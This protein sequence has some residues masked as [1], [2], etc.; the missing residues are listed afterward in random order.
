MRGLHNTLVPLSKAIDRV[1]ACTNLLLELLHLW[2]PVWQPQLVF[3]LFLFR[4][5]DFSEL[6]NHWQHYF[7]GKLCCLF[8]HLEAGCQGRWIPLPCQRSAT[9][10]VALVVWLMFWLCYLDA[11][12]ELVSRRGPCLARPPQT[13]VE[14]GCCTGCSESETL[15]YSSKSASACWAP[16]IHSMALLSL[17]RPWGRLA[18]ADRPSAY[19]AAD[20]RD[21]LRR[22]TLYSPLQGSYLLQLQSH[23]LSSRNQSCAS[24]PAEE[25]TLFLAYPENHLWTHRML[26]HC[27]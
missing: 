13:R 11:H 8:W 24:S 20:P 6:K 10:I 1:A 19:S 3:I 12:R 27:W 25:G 23:F 22:E 2:P 26:R 14:R 9:M 16:Q 21:Y 18:A 7:A 17:I 15:S 5:L 4:F